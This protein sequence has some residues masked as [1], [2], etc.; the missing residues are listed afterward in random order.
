MTMLTLTKTRLIAGVWEG[1]LR[2]AGDTPPA[3]QVL[4]EGEIVAGLESQHNPQANCWHIRVPVPAHLISD[5]I[6][7]FIIS[8]TQGHT[9]ARFAL[10]SG[11]ALGED[12][13]AE[14]ALLR[15]ELDLLKSAFRNHCQTPQN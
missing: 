3:L 2:G 7:T 15:A 14:V 8:D 9:L 6:Q 4:H 12:I 10:L 1:E 11:E 5:G 13:R